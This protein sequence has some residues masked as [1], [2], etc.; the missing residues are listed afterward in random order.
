[1]DLIK[2]R[3]V[4][5]KLRYLLLLGLG[6][7]LITASLPKI[8]QPYAF[9]SSVYSY[10]IVGEYQGLGV[11]ILLPWLELIVGLCLVTKTCLPASLLLATLLGAIFVFVQASA[12]YRGLSI[13]CGCFALTDASMIGYSTVIRSGVFLLCCLIAALWNA[14][15]LTPSG[16]PLEGHCSAATPTAN[17]S[18]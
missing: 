12:L 5:R 6:V 13:S 17:S 2:S 16:I 1:M 9:L 8:M 4:L 3:V 15:E 11:S 14:K 18:S 10:E 7:T